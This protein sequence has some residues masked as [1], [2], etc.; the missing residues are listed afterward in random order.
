MRV[1]LDRVREESVTWDESIEVDA[2]ELADQGVL[3]I[4]AVHSRGEVSFVHP[5]FLVRARLDYEHRRRRAMTYART[6]A[7]WEPGGLPGPHGSDSGA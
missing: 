1:Q 4:S 5:G 6:A 7:V 2:E 3:A